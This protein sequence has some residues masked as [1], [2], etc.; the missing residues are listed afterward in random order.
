MEKRWTSK[1]GAA[2][3]VAAKRCDGSCQGLCGSFPTPGDTRLVRRDP[4]QVL[5]VERGAGPEELKRAF[6]RLAR[7]FHPDQNPC[8]P[9]AAQQFREVVEAYGLLSD[10]AQ[11][12]AYDAHGWPGS[13]DDGPWRGR[14]ESSGQGSGGSELGKGIRDFVG[15]V[16]GDL[17]GGEIGRAHV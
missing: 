11:R 9:E 1:G 2:M 5:D 8:D 12:R 14:G 15:G 4:Y 13:L 10:P 6:R 7:R 3:G 16:L 17:F